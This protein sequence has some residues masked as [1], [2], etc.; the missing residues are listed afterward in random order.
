M[1]FL[2]SICT[3]SGYAQRISLKTNGLYW[4]AMTPN[5][6]GEF[7]L[8]RH[9]TINTDFDLC[10]ARLN[11]DKK[12]KAAAFSP[13]VRYWIARRP[14]AQHFVG[15]MA[16]GSFYK[17]HNN[18]TKT[19]AEGNSYRRLVSHNGTAWG[20]G[21]T[22][23]YSFVLSRHWSIEA[24]IGAGLLYATELKRSPKENA[25]GSMNADD[26][27]V[28]NNNHKLMFAPL[29]LGISAVYIIR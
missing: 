29:K 7:R 5:I 10:L 24:T 3:I 13:E 16:L 18:A 11:G 9:F 2:L 14:Q 27:T 6:A 28:K 12:I 20:F 17:A 15:L 25:L 21:P 8:S 26:G 19:D 23:G 1:A 4:A 22:Y